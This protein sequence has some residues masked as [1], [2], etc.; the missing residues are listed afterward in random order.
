M[1]VIEFDKE[2]KRKHKTLYQK[3]LLNVNIL[4]NVQ[5]WIPI[6]SKY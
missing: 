2:N 3:P 6:Q 5:N 4:M 1:V